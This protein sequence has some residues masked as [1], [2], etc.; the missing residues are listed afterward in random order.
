MTITE[1]STAVIPE[2]EH[3]MICR[4][5]IFT[6]TQEIR[7]SIRIGSTLKREILNFFKISVF[8]YYK[9]LCLIGINECVLPSCGTARLY[10]NRNVI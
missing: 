2:N 7:Q 4:I 3:R 10:Y 1:R 5:I 9:S 8:G 6:E